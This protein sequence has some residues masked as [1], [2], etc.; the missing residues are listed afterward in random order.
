MSVD[1]R[2]E[3]ATLI[4]NWLGQVVW[5]HRK[6]EPWT[7][8]TTT[9]ADIM[10]KLGHRPRGACVRSVSQRDDE[11]VHRMTMRQACKVFVM[12][13]AALRK[14]PSRMNE[15]VVLVLAV[16]AQLAA[17]AQER[18]GRSPLDLVRCM[19]ARSFWRPAKLV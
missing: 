2:R 4:E 5:L 1:L 13:F 19:D 15:R 3:R 6:L 9:A 18:V 11:P 10:K 16:L 17:F 7:G 12:A 14:L 8:P